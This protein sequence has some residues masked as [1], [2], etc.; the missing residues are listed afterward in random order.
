MSPKIPSSDLLSDFVTN[1]GKIQFKLFSC[2]SETVHNRTVLWP[3]ISD[4]GCDQ[5]FILHFADSKV[6]S[7]G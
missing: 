6:L 7:E 5:L 2:E 1:F 3:Y 4:L